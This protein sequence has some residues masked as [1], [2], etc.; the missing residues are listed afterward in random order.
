MFVKGRYLHQSIDWSDNKM[1]AK[2]KSN[3]NITYRP[4]EII[5]QGDSR[6]IHEEAFRILLRFKSSAAPYFIKENFSNLVV[7]TQKQ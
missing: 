2:R 5:L 4:E 6:E 7:L 3:C 1:Y